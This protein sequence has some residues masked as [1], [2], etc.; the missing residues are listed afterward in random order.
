MRYFF[1]PFT[2]K[3]PT[4]GN[5]VIPRAKQCWRCLVALLPLISE[6]SKLQPQD[7]PFETLD[8]NLKIWKTSL[9]IRDLII[10]KILLSSYRYFHNGLSARFQWSDNSHSASMIPIPTS[11]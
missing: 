10:D 1:V 5:E 2:S 6:S 7:H 9:R 11:L 4:K 3:P 8:R